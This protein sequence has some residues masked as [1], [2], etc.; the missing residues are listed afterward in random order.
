MKPLS[1]RHR[2]LTS[3]NLNAHGRANERQRPAPLDVEVDDKN[4]VQLTE[5]VLPA[6]IKVRFDVIGLI[7]SLVHVL[8]SI[9]VLIIL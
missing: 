7:L 9:F 2:R 3:H 6:M 8:F 5:D 1:T 4:M